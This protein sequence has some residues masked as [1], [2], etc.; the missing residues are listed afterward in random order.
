MNAAEDAEAKSEINTKEIV[1]P[2]NQHK[3]RLDQFLST[4]LE[5]ISRSKI[6]QLIKNGDVTV[7]DK[8]VK[9]SHKVMPG[10]RI[11]IILPPPK[12]YELIAEDIPLNIIYEDAS[13]IVINKQAGIVMHPAFAN[14]TGTLVNALLHYSENLSTLSGDYRPGL[15]HRLDKDTSGLIVVAKNDFIHAGLA[16]QFSNR[17]VQ[18]EY[19]ALVWGHFR[20]KSG[21]IETLINRSTRDRTRMTIS[22]QGKPAIT[23]YEVIEEYPLLSL[24]HVKLET[25]RTHQIRV[26]LSARGHPILGDKIYGGRNKQIIKLNQRDQQLA[27]ELLGLMPRQALHART[28]GFIHPETG[29]EMLFDSELPDD[30]QAMIKFLEQ[31]RS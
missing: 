3:E 14:L 24:L 22:R 21:R 10:E 12:T 5:R 1:V 6:Q 13:L 4:Q 26:H 2:E 17:T 31:Q 11:I 9:P 28:L 16:S 8:V 27:L 7:N 25:G 23:N 18:R 19:R 15:V 20:Q 29:K 30:I